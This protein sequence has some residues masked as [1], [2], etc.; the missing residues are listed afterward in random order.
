MVHSASASALAAA[1]LR[2]CTD[3]D[4]ALQLLPIAEVARPTSWGVDPKLSSP[5][6]NAAAL[7]FARKGVG[8]AVALAAAPDPEGS[9]LR[10]LAK[11]PQKSVRRVV[12]TNK[13][14]DTDTGMYLLKWAVKNC[15][16]D[17]I[18]AL[19]ANMD[20]RVL[21]PWL[22][23]NYPS[24]AVNYLNGIDFPY[25]HGGYTID[26]LV[27]VPRWASGSAYW[28]ER[29]LSEEEYAELFDQ[30]PLR[31]GTP[32][33]S[34]L[35]LALLRRRLVRPTDTQRAEDLLERVHGPE[36]LLM[37]RL[38]LHS[39]AKVSDRLLD[40]LTE[41]EQP[42]GDTAGDNV[43]TM[44]RRG[45]RF[46]T[47]AVRLTED[48]LLRLLNLGGSYA[49]WAVHS[50][51]KYPRGISREVINEV[52]THPDVV[53][54]AAA[55]T[56]IAGSYDESG[57]SW[58]SYR[59]VDDATVDLLVQQ[60]RAARAGDVMHGI[61]HL[62]PRVSR[63]AKAKLLTMLAPRLVSQWMSGRIEGCPVELDLFLDASAIS[64]PAWIGNGVDLDS[65]NESEV[66]DILGGGI[67][68]FAD[69][70][71]TSQQ[72]IPEGLFD[73]LDY[74]GR[75]TL[76]HATAW[77][78]DRSGEATVSLQ[79]LTRVLEREINHVPEAWPVV[80]QLAENWTGSLTELASTGAAMFGATSA[81]AAAPATTDAQEQLSLV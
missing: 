68:S 22:Q 61:S 62:F 9:N 25:Q 38:V 2:E 32:G 27:T 46:Y 66:R 17:T 15:D 81:S 11:F 23:E 5:L 67:T 74:A 63:P 19:V 64:C 69:Q 55:F 50:L 59:L 77:P 3:R 54:D 14:L 21:V 56:A 37:A 28:C 7:N 34:A 20:P 48:Q 78:A 43:E 31:G 57:P 75:Q 52:L 42:L 71:R 80:L 73:L 1:L 36:R 49:K 35:K 10:A 70:V 47:C 4:V 8:Y 6:P 18:Q 12:A 44:S 45:A 33:D 39:A 60:N 58:P 30:V 29:N 53:T 79:A 65:L 51:T 24:L 72:A 40:L 26:K 76:R 41:D 13:D 16:T